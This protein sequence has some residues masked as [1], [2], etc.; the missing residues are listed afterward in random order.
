MYHGSE[1]TSIR[2]GNDTKRDTF[3]GGEKN[4]TRDQDL[5]IEVLVHLA[6]DGNHLQSNEQLQSILDSPIKDTKLPL[7]ADVTVSRVS[8]ADFDECSS[9]EHNDC[10]DNAYC[11]NVEGSYECSCKDGYH[12]LSG[13]DSLTGRVCSGTTF[14]KEL[15]KHK[16][17]F[18][19]E[20]LTHT[21]FS[22]DKYHFEWI[23]RNGVDEAVAVISNLYL[24]TARYVFIRLSKFSAF[25]S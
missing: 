24:I 7:G 20:N 16:F 21:K 8:V 13:P 10:A 4:L 11:Y 1:I 22:K 9:T 14:I 12:D 3:Y 25:L 23:L 6:E 19:F 5:A 18:L 2:V 15:L 17:Y